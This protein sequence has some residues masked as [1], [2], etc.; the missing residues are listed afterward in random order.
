MFKLTEAE[1]LVTGAF[2]SRSIGEVIKCIVLL[3]DADGDK[4]LIYHP[5]VK[6]EYPSIEMC[7][8]VDGM[9]Q[10]GGD[11]DGFINIDKTPR[12]FEKWLMGLKQ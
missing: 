6:G 1:Y 12:K 2:G 9:Y 11:P 5:W 3:K 4:A 10:S 8:L 7:D